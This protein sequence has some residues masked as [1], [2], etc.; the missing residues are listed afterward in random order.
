MRRFLL[1]EQFTLMESE[2]K[3]LNQRTQKTGNGRTLL[4]LLHGSWSYFLVCIVSG[5]VFTGCELL[6]PQIIRVSVDSFIG[7]AAVH[8]RAAERVVAALGGTEH[9][10]GALWIPAAV[11]VG[12]GLLSAM[13]RFLT[14]LY[15]AKAGE[16]LVKTSRDLLYGHIQHLP[17]AWHSKNPTGDIIQRCTSDVERIKQFFQE[18]FV[19]VFR[20]IAMIVLSLTCMA[21]MNWK[22]ALVPGLMFPIIVGYSVLFHNRIRDRVHGLRRERGRALDDRAGESDRRARGACVWPRK[23]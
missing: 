4:R 9:I 22:L 1:T 20:M 15:S 5:L 3:R 10:R 16:T 11:L 23:F 12:V 18:Q 14:N 19:A 17:W 7:N 2:G 13:F 21:L 6:I 8:V